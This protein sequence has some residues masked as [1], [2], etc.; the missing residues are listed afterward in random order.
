MKFI[1]NHS[2]NYIV[3]FVEIEYKITVADKIDLCYNIKSICLEAYCGN[4]EKR[5]NKP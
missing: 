1:P 4:Q 2:D 3:L 5:Q